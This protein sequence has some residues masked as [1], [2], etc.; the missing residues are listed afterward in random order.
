MFSK[1]QEQIMENWGSLREPL[2]SIVCITFN[3]EQYISQALDGFLM[4]KTNFPF[5][6]VIH[7]D[8]STDKTADIIRKYEERY[9][10]IIKP[11]YET[12]NQYSK[13]GS[14]FIRNLLPSLKGKYIA[15]CEG[16]DYWTNENKLQMQV[17]FLESHSDYGFCCTDVDIYYES[18]KK[19]E[20]A[21]TKNKKNFLDFENAI[22]SKGYLLNLTWVLKKE[23]YFS[24]F[25]KFE[26]CYIDTALQLFYEICLN[27]KGKYLNIVTGVY[28]RNMGSLSCFSEDQEMKKFNYFKSWFKL[29][30]E[31]IPKFDNE[32]ENELEV[33][34]FGIEFVLTPALLFDDRDII[35][36]YVSYIE[37]TKGAFLN[38]LCDCITE[39]EKEKNLI[40]NSRSYRLG[41]FILFPI[42]KL[43]KFMKLNKTPLK[44]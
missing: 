40:L 9:P 2:V 14:L 29:M 25:S 1:R 36:D 28:R 38:Q 35:I 23:L 26:C 30:K 11:I 33:Y 12:E 27:S 31:Y 21:I 39:K 7:D 6:V 3:H 42:R 18:T 16:D 19:Y 43:L 32:K 37:K 4:Q 44:S 8:A 20:R 41:K 5:E 22:N 15:G 24:F 17:N 10:Q 34:K 13:I